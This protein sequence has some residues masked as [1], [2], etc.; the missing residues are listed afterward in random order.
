MDGYF[1]ILMADI[2]Q[3]GPRGFEWADNAHTKLYFSILVFDTSLIY[4]TMW[5][6]KCHVNQRAVKIFCLSTGQHSTSYFNGATQ[7][8]DQSDR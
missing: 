2:L 4:S 6:L 7:W 5:K 8:N 3:S 1:N